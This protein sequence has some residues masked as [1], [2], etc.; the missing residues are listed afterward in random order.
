MTSADV[1][2]KF[3]WVNALVKILSVIV[4]LQVGYEVGSNGERLPDFY[5]NDLDNAL[6]PVIH[7]AIAH[8]QDGPII[9]EL[10]L[11]IIHWYYA[12]IVALNQDQRYELCCYL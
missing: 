11:H 12:A 4:D 1:V 6:I 7:G 10:V 2:C 9:M 8:S 3:I 5:I